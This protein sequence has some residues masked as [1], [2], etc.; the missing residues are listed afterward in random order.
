MISEEDDD[1]T[2]AGDVLEAQVRRLSMAAHLRHNTTTFD[3][4]V[5]LATAEDDSTGPE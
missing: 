3:L 2:I 4:P 5:N 1:S